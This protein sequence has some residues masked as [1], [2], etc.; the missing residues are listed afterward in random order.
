MASTSPIT[1]TNPLLRAFQQF[2]RME[3]AGGILLLACAVLA[4]IWANSPF[5]DAYTNLWNTPVTVGVGPL[6]IDKPLILWINDGLMAIFFFL[7]GLEIKREVLMGELSDAKK[8]GLAVA[9]ALGGMLAPALGYVAF[10]WGTE[11]ISGW[12]IPM[13]TDIAFA[14]GVLALLG[15]RAPLAL[16]VFLTALAIVDDLGAVLVIALFYTAEVS[17][18]SLGVGAGFLAAL[19]AANKLG[20]RRT[21]VY[22][23]LG[24]GLWVAFLK[25]G[26]HA[27]IAGVLLALTI[28]ASRVIDAPTLAERIRGLVDTFRQQ[29]PASATKGKETLSSAQKDALH[30]LEVAATK[31]DAPLMRMEHALHGW[32]AFFIIPVFALANAGVTIGGDIGAAFANPVTLGIIVG[33]VVGKQIGIPLFAF[34][35][36]KMG[37]AALPDGISWRQIWGVSAICGIGFTMSLFIANLAFGDPALL[38]SAKIGILTASLVSGLIGWFLLTRGPAPT[39]A[40][41]EVDPAVAQAAEVNGTTAVPAG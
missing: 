26:V 19:V 20:V 12:G 13:A 39:E 31:A 8:A 38:D 3:A 11:T 34:V 18:V 6:V 1:T 35:A 24:I 29:A 4:L 5:V 10:N 30:T 36:V 9:G 14:L 22:V 28:P 23:L 17:M 37:V 21:S 15:K 16:K 40:T 25:S 7:V 27:T 33:L 41:P 2:I 32:V